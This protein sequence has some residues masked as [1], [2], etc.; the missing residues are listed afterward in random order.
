MAKASKEKA[1]KVE[2][3]APVAK[4]SIK[5]PVE[6][7]PIKEKAVKGPGVISTII[8]AIQRK[9]LT[10]AEIHQILVAKFPE[11]QPDGMA[12]TVSI[13]LGPTRLGSKF[14]LIKDGDRFHIA[15]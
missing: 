11:R 8:E 10:K 6:K 15:G 1:E 2:K 13:Q 4:A 7:T 3:A 9:P 12:K 5:A 14:K